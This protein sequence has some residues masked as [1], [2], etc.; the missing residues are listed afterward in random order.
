M[1][2]RGRCSSQLLLVA[3]GVGVAWATSHRLLDPISILTVVKIVAVVTMMLT[4]GSGQLLPSL[5]PVVARAAVSELPVSAVAR[6]YQASMALMLLDHHVDGFLGVVQV[7]LVVITSSLPL[8]LVQAV[9]VV[10]C[11]AAG[12]IPSAPILEQKRCAL[13]CL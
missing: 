4:A 9:F 10:I 13:R 7:K 2:L 6:L 11:G 12:P 8:L 3:D 5:Q 1:V